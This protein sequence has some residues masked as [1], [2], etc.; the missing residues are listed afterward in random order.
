MDWC[1][2][3][4]CTSKFAAMADAT[5]NLQGKNEDQEIAALLTSDPHK[6]FTLVYDKYWLAIYEFAYLRIKDHALAEN[7][8]QDVFISFWQSILTVDCAAGFAPYLFGAARNRVYSNIK[9]HGLHNVYL[10]QV[11]IAATLT[12]ENPEGIYQAKELQ[13]KL[14]DTIER[15]PAQTRKV[16]LLSRKDGLTIAQIAEQ[17]NI[18]S[19]TVETHLHNSLKFLRSCMKSELLLILFVLSET[20][21]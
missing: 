8:V 13:N 12:T 4:Q 19:R 9:K 18:S 5:E 3:Q 7:I 11:S 2:S 1:L 6:A 21:K 17:L 16:F 10:G 20:T 14:D 15:L